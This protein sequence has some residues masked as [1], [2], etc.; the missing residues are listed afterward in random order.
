M[1]FSRA[2]HEVVAF[3][4]NAINGAVRPR[5]SHVIT[6]DLRDIAEARDLLL[7][8]DA[9]IHLA[10]ED[11]NSSQRI[12]I[13]RAALAAM[14][15]IARA[16]AAPRIVVYT[17]GTAILGS[18]TG[19]AP[20]CDHTPVSPSEFVAWRPSHEQLTLDAQTSQVATAVVRP[21]KVYGSSGGIMGALFASARE[22]GAVMF[23]GEGHERWPTVHVDD[24]A[25]L[26]LKITE[27]AREL[28]QWDRSHRVFN[29]VDGS[30]H[31]VRAIAR[32]ASHAAG[33]DGRVVAVPY[34]QARSRIG[35]FADN[36]VLDQEVKTTNS[37]R[38]DWRPRMAG[39]VENAE[40]M[41][42]EH[43]AD[44]ANPHGLDARQRNC[45][46]LRLWRD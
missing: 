5:V 33:C 16:A 23:T 8:C 28:V 13:D 25:D 38:V 10:I 11:A 7:S 32:A 15:E 12:E 1:R 41:Y 24:L 6:K 31:P 46:L 37:A 3:D 42:R 30:C 35:G 44:L 36:L 26:Y 22:T 14:L 39:F 20:A 29:A 18:T 21:S 9:M 17:S 27:R 19:R 45:P 43:V 40:A 34:A 4:R 2:G